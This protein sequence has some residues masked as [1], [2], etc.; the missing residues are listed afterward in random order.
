MEPQPV[1]PKSN[2]ALKVINIVCAVLVLPLAWLALPGSMMLYVV[3]IVLALVSVGCSITAL[4]KK[5]V[6]FG[7][8]M[9]LMGLLAGVITV[10][11]GAFLFLQPA[12]HEQIMIDEQNRDAGEAVM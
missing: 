12:H 3:A 10:C 7:V 6:V 8:I 5:C 4:Y 11:I 1:A 2:E 9:L